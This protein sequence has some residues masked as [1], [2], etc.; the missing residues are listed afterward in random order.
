MSTLAKLDEET[1][2][3]SKPSF[4]KND[5]ILKQKDYINFAK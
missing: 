2:S 5:L 3:I 4:W 1:W